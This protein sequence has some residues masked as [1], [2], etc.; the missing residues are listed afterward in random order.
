[1]AG[2]PSRRMK[3]LAFWRRMLLS[4]VVN[5][6]MPSVS[7]SNFEGFEVIWEF[8]KVSTLSPDS[9]F[10]VSGSAMIGGV[11]TVRHRTTQ[12]GKARH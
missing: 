6:K 3:K 9:I 10:D 2:G 11:A 8:I 7:E 1:M 4:R 5:P 12:T